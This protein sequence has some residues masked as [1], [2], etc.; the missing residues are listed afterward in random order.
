M[1]PISFAARRIRVVMQ[2]LRSQ[3]AWTPGLDSFG[4]STGL[5]SCIAIEMTR[6]TG[7]AQDAGWMKAITTQGRIMQK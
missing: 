5:D 4:D 7:M 6:R 1:S 3:N 2:P